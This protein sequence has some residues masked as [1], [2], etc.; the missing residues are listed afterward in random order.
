M[1]PIFRHSKILKK[2]KKKTSSFKKKSASSKTNSNHNSPTTQNTPPP[3]E[4]R[5]NTSIYNTP[6]IL[7]DNAFG[8]N[9]KFSN[10]NF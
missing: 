2:L 1:D 3:Q 4:N 5:Y 9:Q 6:T 7:K 10:V 8:K